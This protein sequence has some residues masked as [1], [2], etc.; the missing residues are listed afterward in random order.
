MG[1]FSGWSLDANIQVLIWFEK[2]KKHEK[3]N[4]TIQTLLHVQNVNRRFETLVESVPLF[5]DYINEEE[6]II[7]QLGWFWETFNSLKNA[8]VLNWL[9]SPFDI[10]LPLTDDDWELL[11]PVLRF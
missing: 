8:Q 6:E 2:F 11:C 5:R 9:G 7:Q 10:V 1:R 3:S 4:A